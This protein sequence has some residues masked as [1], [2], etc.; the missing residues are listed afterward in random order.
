MP[1][2]IYSN[3][4]LTYKPL[5]NFYKKKAI[6]SRTILSPRKYS[7]KMFILLMLIYLINANFSFLNLFINLPHFFVSRNNFILILYAIN[8]FVIIHKNS[9]ISIVEV[10]DFCTYY[11]FEILIQLVVYYYS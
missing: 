1:T 10:C 8:P 4:L 3:F 7:F 5:N 2:E 6:F 11:I 9:L